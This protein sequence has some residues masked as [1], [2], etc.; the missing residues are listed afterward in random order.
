MAA[1]PADGS[2]G[3]RMEKPHHRRIEIKV[4]RGIDRV[5]HFAA[6]AGMDDSWSPLRSDVQHGVTAVQIGRV[7]RCQGARPS[8]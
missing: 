2:F 7:N 5:L 6:G 1:P 8:A 3:F 4:H